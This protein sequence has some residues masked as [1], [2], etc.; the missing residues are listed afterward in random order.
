MR[1]APA[2]A[3]AVPA[4]AMAAAIAI[5]NE[6]EE[7][8]EVWQVLLARDLFERG[9]LVWVLNFDPKTVVPYLPS[10]GCYSPD[11]PSSGSSYRSQ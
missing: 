4:I 2:E 6:R 3:G 11:P 9:Q 8:G 5:G 10:G 7:P 1:I